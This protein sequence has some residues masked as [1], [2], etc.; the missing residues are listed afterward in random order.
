[1]HLRSLRVLKLAGSEDVSGN[2]FDFCFSLPLSV[3]SGLV[4]GLACRAALMLMRLCGFAPVPCSGRRVNGLRCGAHVDMRIIREVSLR[5]CKDRQQPQLVSSCVCRD[6]RCCLRHAGRPCLRLLCHRVWSLE[7]CGRQLPSAGWCRDASCVASRFV[8]LRAPLLCHAGACC[9]A[10]F[11]R[12][13]SSTYVVCALLPVS[14]G[15]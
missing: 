4:I 15:V 13:G 6:P 1:M 14:T 7:P 11:Q 3:P 10:E 12:C 9:R 2:E 5:G 8:R